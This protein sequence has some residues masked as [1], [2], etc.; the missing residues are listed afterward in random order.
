[1]ESKE[2]HL[3]SCMQAAHLPERRLKA[4]LYPASELQ[5]YLAAGGKEGQL[6]LSNVGK[7]SLI[8]ALFSL[9][10]DIEVRVS[11]TPGHTKKLNFFRVGRAFTV[12]DMPGYGYRAPR[13]FVEIVESYLETSLVRTFLLVDGVV[14]L[15]K[16]DRVAVEMCEE[17]GL[18]YVI[19][20]TKIDKGRQGALLRN[21]IQLQ[22]IIQKHTGA[23]YPQ[24]F[25]VSSTSFSGVYL[26]RSF[27]AHVTG[28]LDQGITTNK[29]QPERVS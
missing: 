16:A 20:L 27:I 9:V 8:R 10:P 11:K 3:A 23:C 2:Q 12:V 28:N 21:L 13:D 1:M 18:P 29:S 14:G 15:Q 4:L 22:E 19:V 26:L 6:T 5:A 24:P 17:F 25:L 7:S